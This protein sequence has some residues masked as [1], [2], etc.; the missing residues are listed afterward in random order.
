MAAMY[1]PFLEHSLAKYCRNPGRVLTP[2]TAEHFHD[3]RN[4]QP[5]CRHGT[6][7]SSQY[8]HNRPPTHNRL[9]IYPSTCNR[10]PSKTSG[11]VARSKSSKGMSQF[12]L[13]TTFGTNGCFSRGMFT[14]LSKGTPKSFPW[15]TTMGARGFPLRD[16]D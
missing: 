7:N 6:M 15:V 13:C 2:F 3:P 12:P 10:W 5:Q 9:P 16:I 8:D 1:F 14:G 4:H 11:L